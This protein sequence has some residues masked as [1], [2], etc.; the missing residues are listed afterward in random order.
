MT[1]HMEGDYKCKIYGSI[2]RSQ[3]SK[4]NNIL[5]IFP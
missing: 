2:Q 3:V 5:F 4:P 1:K